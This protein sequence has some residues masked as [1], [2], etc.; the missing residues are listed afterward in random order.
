MP[1]PASLLATD[2]IPARPAE[3]HLVPQAGEWALWRDLAVRTA[4]FPVSGLDIFGSPDE[5]AGLRA[6]AR[7]PMFRTAVTWQNRPRC[8]TRSARSPPESPLL[9]APSAG[10]KR[11]SPAAGGGTAP[12]T[13]RSASSGHWPGDEHLTTARPFWRPAAVWSAKAP[14]VFEAWA[15][16][17]LAGTGLLGDKRARGLVFRVSAG[18]RQQRPTEPAA[19]VPESQHR[20]RYGNPA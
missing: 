6:V 11:S 8:A 10:G 14:R 15:I 20:N 9:A 4:G 18:V 7:D 2:Q 12:R 19:Q 5:Q 3:P 16:Q 17:A 1:H 13:T